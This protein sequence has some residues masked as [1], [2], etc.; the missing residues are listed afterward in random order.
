MKSIR[1]ISDIHGDFDWYTQTITRANIDDG[2]NTLQLGDF[3]I[4]FPRQEEWNN[5]WIED[6][7]DHAKMN[8][9]FFGNHDNPLYT[10][11]SPLFLDRF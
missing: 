9:A 2:I 11:N 10:R 7:G 6:T 5:Y 1:I 8:K 4:G 3:G